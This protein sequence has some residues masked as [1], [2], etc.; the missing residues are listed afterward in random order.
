VFVLPSKMET[1]GLVVNEALNF[2][3]PVVVSDRVGCAADLVRDGWNGFVVP[4]DDPAGFAEALRR[5]VSD[6]DLREEL[7]ARGRSL[8]DLYSIDACANGIV[9]ACLAAARATPEEAT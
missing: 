4:H 7:G 5:L 1:W 6:A 3:L 9:A 8:V 2:S